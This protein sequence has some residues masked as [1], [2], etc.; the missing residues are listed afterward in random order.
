MIF[1]HTLEKVLSGEKTQTSRLIKSDTE[2]V[3]DGIVIVAVMQNNRYQYRVGA[4]YRVQP[5]R[6]QG[7]IQ[8]IRIVQIQNRDVR[9]FDESD[10]AREG[11]SSYDEF[12]KAWATMHDIALVKGFDLTG[13][14][15]DYLYQRPHDRYQAWVLVFELV[16]S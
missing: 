8:R 12:I 3:L 2:V 16:R 10:I 13:I 4:T 14:T 11:F 15:P 1:E 5:A 7:G 9:Y 6:G